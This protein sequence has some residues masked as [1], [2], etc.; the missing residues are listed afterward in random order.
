VK[1]NITCS[2]ELICKLSRILPADVIDT[3][4]QH[5]GT[6][7]KKR[8]LEA[9]HYRFTFLP[10]N[11][12]STMTH[13]ERELYKVAA[14]A[15]TNPNMLDKDD[16]SNY[17]QVITLFKCAYFASLPTLPRSSSSLAPQ[18][19]IQSQFSHRN[20]PDTALL[21]STVNLFNVWV[22]A[23]FPGADT[24]FRELASWLGI[25]DLKISPEN[26]CKEFGARE[27]QRM[28][29]SYIKKKRAVLGPSE[30]TTVSVNPSIDLTLTCSCVDSKCYLVNDFLKSKELKISIEQAQKKLKHVEDRIKYLNANNDVLSYRREKAPKGRLYCLIIEKKLG[31]KIEKN[32]REF[33]ILA[34][35]TESLN[36]VKKIV[37]P[38]DPSLTTPTVPFTTQFFPPNQISS[39]EQQQQQQ[40]Q[41][42]NQQQQLQPQQKLMPQASQTS[43]QQPNFP[44]QQQQQ[45]QPG[46]KLVTANN[47]TH[48]QTPQQPQQLLQMPGMPP[49]QQ[50]MPPFPGQLPPYGQQP[51]FHPWYMG[52]Q[53]GVMGPAV[54]A[55]GQPMTGGMGQGYGA[56]ASYPYPGYAQM[57]Q[58]Q[59]QITQQQITQQQILQ[60]QILQ[61]QQILQPHLFPPQQPMSQQPFGINLGMDST[62][63]HNTQKQE[64]KADSLKRTREI[65]AKSANST[66]EGD[67]SQKKRKKDDDDDDSTDSF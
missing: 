20:L 56:Y 7:D 45:Q 16:I 26:R 48:P 47:N 35:L 63:N 58:P 8:I 24:V 5:F 13:G 39:S 49:Q 62:A 27:F 21:T 42:Q 22:K 43:P 28:L 61:P 38:R 60:P 52:Q 3:V 25:S 36:T 41:Q 12:V 46:N 37:F 53:G 32:K 29:E 6:M 10:M 31:A 11:K 51:I 34:T 55:M 54:G 33:Q 57:R 19:P 50:S 44:H 66:R 40:Q 15:F 4:I 2:N 23:D 18:Y 59:Q 65:T 67:A 9:V 14:R 64:N 30:I 1:T 17:N